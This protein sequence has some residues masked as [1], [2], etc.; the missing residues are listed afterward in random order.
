MTTP[1]N[2]YTH[3]ME[4]LNAIDQTIPPNS[5]VVSLALFEG[6]LLYDTMHN[7]QVSGD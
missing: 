1:E 4:A 6:E 7:Q 2:F 5:Y 3:A